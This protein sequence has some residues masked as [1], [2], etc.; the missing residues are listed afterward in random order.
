MGIEIQLWP[1]DTTSPTAKRSD[2]TPSMKVIDFMPLFGSS[3]SA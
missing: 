2:P 1:V 3:K